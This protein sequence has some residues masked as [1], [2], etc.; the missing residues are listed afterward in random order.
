MRPQESVRSVAFFPGHSQWV[1]A[2]YGDH[3]VR[4]WDTESGICYLTLRGHT[5][6]M[7]GADVGQT[8]N[9][10]VTGS[11]EGHVKFWEYKVL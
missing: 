5:R 2:S 6:W 11:E 8:H 4:V 1:V 7:Y 10:L 9:L 3:T